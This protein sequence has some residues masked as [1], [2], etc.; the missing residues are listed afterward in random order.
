M[1]DESGTPIGT[2]PAPRTASPMQIALLALALA[3]SSEE[4]ASTRPDLVTFPVSDASDRHARVHHDLTTDGTHWLRGRDYK[5][6]AGQDGLTFFPFL[7][8]DAPRNFPVGLRLQ[9]ASRDGQ[10][11]ELGDEASVARTG[12]RIVIDRGG[13][14]VRYDATPEFVEQSFVLDVPTGTG[15]LTL[16][17]DVETELS[18]VDHDGGFRFEGEFGGVDYGAA[19]A[20]DAKGRRVG[21]PVTWSGD[22]FHLTIPAAFLADAQS[23]LVVDPVLSGFT[24]GTSTA[25]LGAPDVAYGGVNT[26]FNVVYEE[27]FS[28][29]DVDI[30]MV[31]VG[32]GGTTS[33]GVY[34]DQTADSWRNP[35]IATTSGAA[36]PLIVA[37]APSVAF[38]GSTDIVARLR[39][40]D[41]TL[42]AA[43][44]LKSATAAYSCAAPAIAGDLFGQA[45]SFC[46]AY[47]RDYGTHR[48]LHYVINGGSP[49]GPNQIDRTVVASAEEDTSAPS[50]TRATGIYVDVHYVIAWSSRNLTTGE[51]RVQSSRLRYDGNQLQGP[52]T[53]AQPTTQAFYFDVQVSDR[54]DRFPLDGDRSY[55][56]IAYDDRPSNVSDA[57]IALYNGTSVLDTFELQVA[58]HADR[59]PNQDDVVIATGPGHFMV[60]YVEN[61][62]LYVTTL[63]PT[64]NELGILERRL[65]VA[66]PNIVGGSLAALGQL[67]EFPGSAPGRSLFLW[68]DSSGASTE[69]RGALVSLPVER[70]AGGAQYCYGEPNSTGER[71]FL[72]SFGS[73]IPGFDHRLRVESLPPNNF[74]YFLA[75]LTQNY[76][77]NVGGSQGAL[78]VGGA[79]GRF[80]IFQASDNGT[81]EYT[82]DTDQIPQPT[83]PVMSIGGQVWSFQC[84]HRD[85]LSGMATSN[86]TNG[87]TIRFR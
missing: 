69:I 60:G 81:S 5:A 21:V 14:Q 18:L 77:P 74:G 57:F 86:L 16:T 54:T 37:E 41:G 42:G 34:V 87:T 68:S 84:W 67:F 56:V 43:Y 82:L 11:V 78:C 27:Q 76:V 59:T 32:D 17:L 45:F 83:G 28:A 33:H 6:S 3:S 51:S 53:V 58:E 65:H 47:N 26:N 73:R 55:Y 72:H 79:V 80:G 35:R 31:Q 8:S 44:I 70:N 25:D 29:T 66:G 71:G 62:S 7:G 61:G 9:G 50:I 13:V 2:P 4:A 38:P 75:S 19:I 40:T 36:R 39:Q 64:F 49:P 23:P 1:V 48:D 20:I 63:E 12:N 10:L 85:S 24:I 46:I 22:Q 30:Y 15:P 52:F